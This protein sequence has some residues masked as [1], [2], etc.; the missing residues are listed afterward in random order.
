MAR[1]F[2]MVESELFLAEAEAFLTWPIA[3]SVK[4][5]PV[6]NPELAF[7]DTRRFKCDY[8]LDYK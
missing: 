8:L 2:D 3:F 7:G 4:V 1:V 6:E 5:D